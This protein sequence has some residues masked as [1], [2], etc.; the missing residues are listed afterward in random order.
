[1]QLGELLRLKFPS[2][3]SIDG[4]RVQDDGQGAYIK[5]WNVPV[6]PKPTQEDLD[7]WALELDLQYRQQQARNSRVYPS[8]Q[9]QA[10]MQY[11]DSINGTTV[12]QDTITAIKEANPIPQE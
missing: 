3:D 6:I 7:K 5:E 12:W 10:D 9:E 4:Y 11:W 8:I 1:M 2:I